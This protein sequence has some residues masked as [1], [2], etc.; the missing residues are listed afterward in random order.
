MPSWAPVSLAASSADGQQIR[1]ALPRRGQ[2]V[3]QPN[4]AGVALIGLYGVM[5]ARGDAPGGSSAEEFEAKFR[6]ALNDSRTSAILIDV[7]SPGGQ[8]HGMDE[9]SRLIFEARGVKPIVA[10][11]NHLMASAAYW[12]A[13]AAGEVVMT[14]SAEVGGIGVF[15]AHQDVS[16][17]I[18]RKGIKVTL[19]SAGRYKV[20]ASPYE[21]LSDQARAA[22]QARVDDYYRMFADA[23]ARNRG[24][25]VAEVLR[26]Y[27]EGRTVGVREALAAGM[28]DRVETLAQTVERLGRRPTS[29]RARIPGAVRP[30]PT[31]AERRRARAMVELE[32]AKLWAADQQLTTLQRLALAEVT[33]D[34]VA[35][36]RAVHIARRCAAALSLP[37]APIVSWFDREAAGRPRTLGLAIADHRAIWLA[38]ALPARDLAFTVAHECRHL[39]QASTWPDDDYRHGVDTAARKAREADANSWAETFVQSAG[40][41]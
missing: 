33:P 6:A 40:A 30:S 27:G 12:V 39:W 1:A 15:A 19:I 9:L 38:S 20:E 13:S 29:A 21:P 37:Y 11:A 24:V 22:L 18:E 5:A 35:H 17:A 26:G 31:D 28:V 14:P 4:R 32:R 34:A 3:T 10:L 25:S 36:S 2:A 7:W 23:V 8:V 16:R 41:H